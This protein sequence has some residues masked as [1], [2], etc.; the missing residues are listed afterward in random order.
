MVTNQRKTPAGKLDPDLMAPSSVEPDMNQTG[1]SGGNPPE[2]QPGF[3]NAGPLALY[4]KD[5]ILP[6][7]LP[8]QVF[9][10][11]LFR[12]SAMDHGYVFFHHSSFLYSSG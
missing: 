7:V 2:F 6:A 12:R 3:L 5:L 4:H 9:P 1:F 8:E 10:V 11:A